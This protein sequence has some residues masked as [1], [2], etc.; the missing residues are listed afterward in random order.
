MNDKLEE[1]FGRSVLPH[2]L[3]PNIQKKIRWESIFRWNAV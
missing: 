2:F 1:M 3:Y